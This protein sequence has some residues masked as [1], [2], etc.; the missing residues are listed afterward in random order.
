MRIFIGVLSPH[1]SVRT[2]VGKSKGGIVPPELLDPRRF[3]GRKPLVQVSTFVPAAASPTPTEVE[4]FMLRQAADKDAAF[5]LYDEAYRGLI[6]NLRSSCFCA[7]VSLDPHHP[8]MQNVFRSASTKAIK[9]W[10]QIFQRFAEAKDAKVLSLPLRNF[11]APELLELANAVRGVSSEL[12]NDIQSGLSQLKKRLRPRRKSRSKTLYLVDDS[13]RFFVF[14]HERHSI[15]ET[16]GDHLPSCALNAQFRFGCRI[17]GERHYNVSETE[18]DNTVIKG[19]FRN[20]HDVEKD[21]TRPTHLNM[22]SNDMY[23]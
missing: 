14:G 15:P 23:F 2:F 19:I 18:G 1:E 11:H 20:C 13:K 10:S 3:G 22:F 9:G 8:K 12:G 6:K 16:G 5:I 4:A 21:E 17:D 7:E